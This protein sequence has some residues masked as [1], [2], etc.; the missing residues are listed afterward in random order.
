MD[1]STIITI[2]TGIVTALGGAAIGK[3]Q[4]IAKAKKVEAE[5][6]SIAVSST[7]KAVKMWEEL[8]EQLRKDLDAARIR[9]D[10][11]QVEYKRVHEENMELKRKVAGMEQEIA[12]LKSK[13]Q[14]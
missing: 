7:E 5:A 2:V 13:L 12:D 9:M 8:N 11:I 6:D 10:E 4:G 14:E 3:R 1:A